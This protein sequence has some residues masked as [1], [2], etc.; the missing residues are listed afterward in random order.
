MERR[1][2]AASHVRYL[3]TVDVFDR[4]NRVEK[5]VA[6]EQPELTLDGDRFQDDSKSRIRHRRV[7]L[8]LFIRLDIRDDNRADER[9]WR[10]AEIKPGTADFRIG[11]GGM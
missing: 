9:R 5:G 10:P 7:I 4:V 8:K 11:Q 1:V 3:Y 6:K 2:R